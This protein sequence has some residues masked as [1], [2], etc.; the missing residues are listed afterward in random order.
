ML[1]DGVG[2]SAETPSI[3]YPVKIFRYA[4]PKAVNTV[5]YLPHL[6]KADLH[7]FGRKIRWIK[8]FYKIYIFRIVGKRMMAATWCKGAS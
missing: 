1:W 2:V 4:Y 8:A 3:N 5:F 6:Q 7:N